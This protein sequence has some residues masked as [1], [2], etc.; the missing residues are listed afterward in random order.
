MPRALNN[1]SPVSSGD[2]EVSLRVLSGFFL[3]KSQL[4]ALCSS[5]GQDTLTSL[6]LPEKNE[7]ILKEGSGSA[8]W[9]EEL[10]VIRIRAKM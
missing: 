3:R 4:T 8:V 10:E 7:K 1:L 5:F 6:G 2:G 9:Q